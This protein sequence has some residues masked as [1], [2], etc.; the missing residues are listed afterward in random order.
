MNKYHTRSFLKIHFQNVYINLLF[1]PF[2][3]NI[4][5]VFANNNH[6]CDH[7]NL[8]SVLTALLLPHTTTERMYEV[9]AR[10]VYVCSYAG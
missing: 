10:N 1:I 6:V 4:P 3:K 9:I 8:Q 5:C 2:K 7:R